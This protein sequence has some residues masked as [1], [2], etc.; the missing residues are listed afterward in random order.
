MI[1]VVQTFHI[2]IVPHL[3]P[4]EG[5]VSTTLQTNAI[6]G[7]LRQQITLRGASLDG[8]L[9]E[10]FVE[11]GFLDL[12]IGVEGDLDDLCLAIGVGREV[13]DSRT[14]CT[15]RH[16][17]LP[18]TNHG[19]HVKSLH[20]TEALLAIAIDDIIYGT[21]VVLL[22]YVDVEHV[23]AHEYLFC[24]TN[25][26]V[27]TI[28]VEDDDIVEVGAVAHKLVLLESCANK[29][30]RAIDIKFLIGF[31]HLRRVDG[32][33][34]ANLC[35]SWMV[36]AIF[37][38]EELEPIGCNLREVRQIAINLFNF[39]LQTGHEL[40]CLLL[41]ELQDALHLDFQQLQ[42]VVLRHLTNHT[43]VVGRQSLIDMLTNL[44]HIGGFLEF[45]VLIDA[46]LDENLFQRIEMQL[47]QEFTLA[48][49]EFLTNQ[50][51][52]AICGVT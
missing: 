30:I 22:E 38:L 16:I 39:S 2:W 4:S 24:H 51:L 19:G 33:E 7:E 45:L 37:V 14:W 40:L 25:H 50:V 11:D 31:C 8:N 36:L 42:D 26:L 13:H 27:F 41:V 5:G 23:L 15:Q 47:L 28:L 17:I 48:D 6:N 21:R 46:L 49:L 9:R 29:A 1:V 52:R 20:E 34:I 43:G 32:V 18:I 3:A 12:R 35:E 10:V 44:I